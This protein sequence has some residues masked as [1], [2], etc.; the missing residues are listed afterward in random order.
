[1]QSIDEMIESTKILIVEANKEISDLRKELR[2]DPDNEFIKAA[3][4]MV[5][6]INRDQRALYKELL[7]ASK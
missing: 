6:E 4:E 2:A 3:I 7:L 5:Q 1:M